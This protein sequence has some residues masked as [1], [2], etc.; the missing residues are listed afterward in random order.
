V[1]PDVAICLLQP[2]RGLKVP[3]VAQWH[4]NLQLFMGTTLWLW[5]FWRIKHD[6]PAL[7]VSVSP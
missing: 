6:G 5:L 2:Y 1:R 7:L 3:K 4:K